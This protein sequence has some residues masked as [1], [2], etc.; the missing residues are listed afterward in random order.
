MNP[1]LKAIAD[2]KF[3]IPLDILNAA[4]MPR[5]F[6]QRPLPV[7]LDVIIREKVV[8]ARVKVDCNLSGGT[9]VNIPLAPIQPEYLDQYT[10]VYRIPKHYSNNRS[11]TKVLDLTVGFGSVMGTTNMG[12]EGAS[13]MLDA[14]SGVLASNAPIPIVSTA[15][16]ELIAENTVLITDTLQFPTDAYLR[17][18]VEY[19][20]D[21]TQ[22][23]PATYANFSKLVEFAVKAFI[24]N[25]LQIRMGQAQLSGGM[26]LGQ[27]KATV[28]KYED[29]EENYQT[30]LKDVWRSVA[31]LD[32]ALSRQ[33]HLRMITGGVN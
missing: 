8:E 28:D 32:D 23:K 16:I 15:Y 33:R 18:M 17:C 19:D 4:F 12:L 9:Q 13:P 2:V 26:D 3:K 25:E 27:F 1:I 11:I 22:L 24:F 21:M 10:I 20:R 30:Y 29:A 5:Q 31:I 14:V 6:G 7:N